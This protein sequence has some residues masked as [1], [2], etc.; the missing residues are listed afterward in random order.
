MDNVKVTFKK[1]PGRNFGIYFE[2]YNSK[3]FDAIKQFIRY[4]TEW[5][6]APHSKTVKESGAY[7]Q[8]ETDDF[9][10]IEFWSTRENAIKVVDILRDDFNL[11]IEIEMES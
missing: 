9:L 10:F 11:N 2:G 1:V 5:L 6:D 7:I 8:S 4:N 3:L